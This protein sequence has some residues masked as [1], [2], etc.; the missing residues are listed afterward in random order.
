MVR[1][2]CRRPATVVLTAVNS[3][4]RCVSAGKSRSIC[5]VSCLNLA[6]FVVVAIDRRYLFG[7][8]Q[9]CAIVYSLRKTRG[10][11]LTELS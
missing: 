10:R 2:S 1:S 11:M 8:L 7:A 3:V 6:R 4:R 5:K 9:P